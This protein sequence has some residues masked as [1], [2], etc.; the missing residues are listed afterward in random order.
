MQLRDSQKGISPKKVSVVAPEDQ[1]PLTEPEHAEEVSYPD[2]GLGSIGTSSMRSRDLPRSSK[3]ANIAAVA[4]ANN[5]LCLMPQDRKAQYA[6]LVH[7]GSEYS[8]YTNT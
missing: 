1:H 3:F 5:K 7:G 6:G 4:K 8:K 2:L